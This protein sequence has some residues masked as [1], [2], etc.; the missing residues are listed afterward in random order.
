MIKTSN[1]LVG[2]SVDLSN[3]IALLDAPQTPVTSLLLQMGLTEP[4]DAIKVE[5]REKNLASDDTPALEGA[6]AAEYATT[7]A[8]KDNYCMI[9]SRQ[10]KVSNT[11]QSVSINGIPNM[12]QDEVQDR[13]FEVKRGIE[14]YII[15]GTK[16]AESGST[17]RQMNGLLNQIH[18]DNQLTAAVFSPDEF[19]STVERVWQSGV[20]GDYYCLTNSTMKG[21][22]NSFANDYI[23]FDG[24]EKLFG[25]TIQR[26]QTDFGTV[27][28]VL[29]SLIPADTIAIGNIN[30]LKL[31]ELRKA[32]ITPLAITGDFVS[33][34]VAWEGSLKLLNSK[35]W[36]KWTKTIQ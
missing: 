12:I 7:R 28:F 9:L 2:E 33:A 23:R 1:L 13:L 32:S 4:A 25:I 24:S 30:Y 15:T 26:F 31:A 11:V 5:W 3:E 34:M 36:A 22:I 21:A 35:A 27:F 6:V 10:A 14:K 29:S 20:M 18:L 19:L 16:T 17:P 8:L